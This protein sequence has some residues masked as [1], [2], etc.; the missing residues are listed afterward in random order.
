VEHQGGN[1][2]LW[3]APASGKRLLIWSYVVGAPQVL[4]GLVVFSGGLTDDRRWKVYPAALAFAP[5]GPP[6]E[7]TEMV[8][9]KHCVDQGVEYAAV[10]GAYRYRVESE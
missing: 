2:Q 9:R 10:A 7:I 5:D 4:D 6:V 1:L 3:H 8:T